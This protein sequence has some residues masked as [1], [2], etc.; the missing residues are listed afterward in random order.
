MIKLNNVVIDLAT[1]E[2]HTHNVDVTEN[3]T[4]KG[5][6]IV[7]HA[8]A[9]PFGLVLECFVSDSPR[10]AVAQARGTITP[11]QVYDQVL[12]LLGT[13]ITVETP[14]G[15]WENMVIALLSRPIAADSGAALR[16]S[17]QLKQVRVVDAAARTQRVALPQ[18]A[19]KKAL[20]GNNSKALAVAAL[21][22]YY[23]N[24]IP[25]PPTQKRKSLLYQG[26]EKIGWR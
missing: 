17:L 9:K 21:K 1:S 20:G 5:Q 2:T 25:N 7:D 10:G 24:I 14:G 13:L 4:E 23:A 22:S 6:P 16:F 3:P 18:V 12:A 8:R 15:R 19:H 26:A 11:A